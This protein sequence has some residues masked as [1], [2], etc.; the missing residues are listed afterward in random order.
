MLFD[1]LRVN[2]FRYNWVRGY[3]DKAELP[4]ETRD[5]FNYVKHSSRTLMSDHQATTAYY[6]DRLDKE[7]KLWSFSHPLTTKYTLQL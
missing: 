7:Y 5:Y 3:G 4:K 1:R 2:W 6:V